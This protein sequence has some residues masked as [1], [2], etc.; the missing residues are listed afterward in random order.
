VGERILRRLVLGSLL[1]FACD[2]GQ[3]ADGPITHETGV[4]PDAFPVPDGWFDAEQAIRACTIAMACE[5]LGLST[6]MCISSLFDQADWN[7]IVDRE[8]VQR[9]LQCTSKPVPDCATLEACYGGTWFDLSTGMCRVDGVCQGDRLTLS[10]DSAA[11]VDCASYG[12]SCVNVAS[13]YG[14]CKRSSCA[15]TSA[16]CITETLGRGC[17]SGLVAF[18]FDCAASGRICSAGECVGPGPPCLPGQRTA[19]ISKSV[20]RYCSG[21]R[22]AIYDCARMPGHQACAV[23]ANP[24]A[25]PCKPEGSE[26]TASWDSCQGDQLV[27]CVN[28]FRRL[29]DCKALGLTGCRVTSPYSMALCFF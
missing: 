16:T 20:A 3:T 12:A 1:V 10:Y 9:M 11:Y 18:D 2:R 29:V 22:E 8:M 6:S 23:G 24:G 5:Q 15:S 27:T 14:C 25:L 19:C 21:G 4:A 7:Q 28:G 26:C 13:N 17:E